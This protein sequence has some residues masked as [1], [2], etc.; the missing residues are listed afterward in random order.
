M[1][2]E[3]FVDALVRGV[4]RVDMFSSGKPDR[5]GQCFFVGLVGGLQGCVESAQRID[6][7]RTHVAMNDDV[8]G[9]RRVIAHMGGERS[10]ITGGQTVRFWTW[11]TR[12]E[13]PRGDGYAIFLC[14]PSAT[15][16]IK[17]RA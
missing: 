1:P 8:A 4:P 10:V 12:I 5:S 7:A 15:V 16:W 11:R 13:A 6:G 3:S 14:I 17:P 2:G 9:M